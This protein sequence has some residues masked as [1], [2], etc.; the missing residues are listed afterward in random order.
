[1]TVY[2]DD[3]KAPY[4]AMIMCHMLATSDAELHDMADRLGIKRGWYQ[5]AGTVHRHYDISMSK[6]GQ[7]VRA[8][9]VQIDRR[10]VAALIQA[11]RAGVPEHCID[12]F[13]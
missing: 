3:M 7:A 5:K 4:R 9:A 11:R 1:M 8:G 12:L 2:V 6:R 10:G 13:V